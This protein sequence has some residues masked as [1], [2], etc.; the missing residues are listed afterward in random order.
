[1]R[2]YFFH[3]RRRRGSDEVESIALSTQRSHAVVMW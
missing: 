1:M 2:N 3:I